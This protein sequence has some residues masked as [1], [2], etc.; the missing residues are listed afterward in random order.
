VRAVTSTLFPPRQELTASSIMDAGLRL[1]RL[2]ALPSLVLSLPM[3]LAAQ[4]PNI[5]RLSHAGRD[6]WW[7][8]LAI[9]G[10]VLSLLFW[11]ALVL[12]QSAI[13]NGQSLG[14]GAALARA[15]SWAPGLMTL[16]VLSVAGIAVGLLLLVVPGLLAI[17]VALLAPY[18]MVFEALRP[19]DACT[20]AWQLI[21]GRIG[22]SVAVIAMSFAVFLVFYIVFS[23][24]GV[25]SA[26]GLGANALSERA[27]SAWAGCLAQALF[28]PMVTAVLLALFQG[29][30]TTPIDPV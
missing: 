15:V 25:M 26:Q 3:V 4:A 2:T 28:L 20:R 18:V 7:W 19:V 12:R 29:L 8:A 21:K 5:Y 17:L 30:V 1:Y 22:P 24:L 10:P 9:A 13:A 23:V 6:P 11:A 27:C 16:A 14:L